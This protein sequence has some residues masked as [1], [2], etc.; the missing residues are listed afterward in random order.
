MSIRVEVSFQ[1]PS[2]NQCMKCNLYHKS[3]YNFIRDLD[4]NIL[5]VFASLNQRKKLDKL[6]KNRELEITLNI[7]YGDLETYIN[8]ESKELNINTSNEISSFNIPMKNFIDNDKIK[9]KY[10]QLPKDLEFQSIQGMDILMACF[11]SESKN[12]AYWWESP[13]KKRD[14]IKLENIMFYISS[15]EVKMN[16]N[17]IYMMEYQVKELNE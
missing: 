7:N 5:Y 4:L 6:K 8:S 11:W 2:N 16:K 10:N 17:N 14:R 1:K 12:M 15:F 13:Y 9:Y 3:S